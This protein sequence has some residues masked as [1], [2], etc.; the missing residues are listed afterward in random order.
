[1]TTKNY[2]LE[3]IKFDVLSNVLATVAH[4]AFQL[5]V[6]DA[7]TR[8]RQDIR[9]LTRLLRIDYRAPRFAKNK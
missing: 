5:Q 4:S 7:R 1:M 3:S 9:Q 2:D 8:H 6:G